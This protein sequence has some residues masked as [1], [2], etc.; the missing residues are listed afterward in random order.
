M[1]WVRGV[2][3]K[4]AMQRLGTG[5]CQH[6]QQQGELEKGGYSLVRPNAA[7]LSLRQILQGI[8]GFGKEAQSMLIATMYLCKWLAFALFGEKAFRR[9]LA[10]ISAE[11]PVDPPVH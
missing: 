2:R 3:V 5:H 6:E 11:L 9:T 4:R 10:S 1:A 8:F 7:E